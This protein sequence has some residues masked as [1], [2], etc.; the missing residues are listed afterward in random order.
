MLLNLW[1]SNHFFQLEFLIFTQMATSKK[2]SYADEAFPNYHILSMP[3]IMSVSKVC[4]WD[5]H[6]SS[7]SRFIIAI[8]TSFLK[9]S[10][11]L[12]LSPFLSFPVVLR[13]GQYC[14]CNQIIFIYPALIV[15]LTPC[16]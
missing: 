2:H 5:F 8:I 16:G 1:L 9:A 10:L 15:R 12:S 13:E 4:V 7:M 14:H 11:S 3:A 6:D